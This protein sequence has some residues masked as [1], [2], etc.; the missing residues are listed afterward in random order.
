MAS[1]PFYSYHSDALGSLP[2]EA[3]NMQTQGA[4]GHTISFTSCQKE[5]AAK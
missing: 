2:L 3:L 5:G 1:R 4:G